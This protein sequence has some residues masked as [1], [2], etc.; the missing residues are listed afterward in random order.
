M[1]N[2]RI[3]AFGNRKQNALARQNR[4]R[5]T[6]QG[7][8]RWGNFLRA[9][10]QSRKFRR[11]RQRLAV[12]LGSRSRSRAG[13]QPLPFALIFIGVPLLV[14]KLN[15][16]MPALRADSADLLQVLLDRILLG[17]VTRESFP[18][19]NVHAREQVGDFHSPCR[20]AMRQHGGKPLGSGQIFGQPVSHTGQAPNGAI[21][22]IRSTCL[23]VR[24]VGFR[25][26]V[27]AFS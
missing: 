19:I 15:P 7:I 20:P 8:V 25:A 4:N 16:V 6:F 27:S 11:P 23:C 2:L 12:F 17:P 10:Q 24:A 9:L 13:P 18:I 26:R 1:S 5:A 21:R 22:S 14:V 3:R